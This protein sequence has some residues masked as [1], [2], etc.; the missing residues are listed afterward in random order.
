MV[1][2]NIPSAPISVSTFPFQRLVT[3]IT[4]ILATDDGDSRLYIM[5]TVKVIARVRPL[6][7]SEIENDK[8]VETCSSVTPSQSTTSG[9]I[10]AA[11][12]TGT[13]SE[14]QERFDTIKIPNPKNAGEKYS[15]QFQAV[16]DEQGTQQEIFE[17]EG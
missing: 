14:S 3:L 6:L 1:S 15:F 11:R 17:R 12:K 7:K 2:L 16:Y 9:T 4:T 8:V 10:G 5:S 13:A